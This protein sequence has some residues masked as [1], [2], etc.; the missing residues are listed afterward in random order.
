MY[1]TR[2]KKLGQSEKL[3]EIARACGDV[4]TDTVTWFWRTVSRQGVWLNK[5]QM[6]RWMCTRRIST[7]TKKTAFEHPDMEAFAGK[8]ENPAATLES[9]YNIAQNTA[10]NVVKEFYHALDS[11]RERDN[12]DANPPFKRKRYYKAN[13]NYTQITL[14]DDGVLRL[15]TGRGNEPV[16]I[17]WP[18]PEPKRVEIGWDGEQYE[19]RVQYQVEP[20]REPKGEKVAGIDLGEVYLATATTGEE[21]WLFNGRHLRSLRRYQNKTKA[22][23]QSKIDTKEKGSRRWQRLVISKRKQ[24]SSLRNQIRDVLHKLSRRLVETLYQEGVSTLVVGDVRDIRDGLDYGA[25]GNQRLHQWAHGAFRHMLTCKAEL[26]GMEVKLEPERDTTKTCPSCGTKNPTRGR[27]YRCSTCQAAF[28]RDEVGA[29]N[30]REKY[31]DGDGWQDGYLSSPVVAGQGFTAAP[32]ETSNETKAYSS[33]RGDKTDQP[34]PFASGEAAAPSTT[35]EAPHERVTTHPTGV[36]FRPHM[37]CGDGGS[38]A[39]S[40]Q[41]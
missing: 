7:D 32:S 25:K 30:I 1:L 20:D 22:T 40:S 5:S 2:K 39:I 10:Q 34:T 6:M 37:D 29:L 35:R 27:K 41:G 38:P 9:R 36:R 12:P 24:L 13:W 11:W 26:A 28:H 3:D 8:R 15:S 4:W 23:L 16:L 21:T 14:R 17:E 31:L 18:H 19:A 33:P